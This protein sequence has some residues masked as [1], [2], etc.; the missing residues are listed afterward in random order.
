MCFVIC[1]LCA[2]E[3]VDSDHSG[4]ISVDEFMA[5][6]LSKQAYAQ[7]EALAA[8][9]KKID[10]DGSGTAANRPVPPRAAPPCIRTRRQLAVRAAACGCRCAVRCRGPCHHHTACICVHGLHLHR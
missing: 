10:L 6:A 8:A 1:L 2:V 4:S 3:Q 9:F 7:R 5:A